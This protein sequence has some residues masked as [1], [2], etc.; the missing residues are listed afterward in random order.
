[1]EI[2]EEVRGGVQEQ[3]MT[4]QRVVLMFLRGAGPRCGSQIS[5]KT[6][7]IVHLNPTVV[8]MDHNI[9][10]GNGLLLVVATPQLATTANNPTILLVTPNTINNST[11]NSKSVLRHT[12][13]HTL[14]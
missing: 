11:L 2:V 8:A 4:S 7:G 5:L 3:A 14:W 10:L 6:L 13:F 12:S 9:L 1:M